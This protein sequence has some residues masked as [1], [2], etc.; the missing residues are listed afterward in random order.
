MSDVKFQQPV[1]TAAT[2]V[3]EYAG[4]KRDFCRAELSDVDL[5]GVDLKGADF[6]YAELSEANL[7]NANLRG[8][9][10]SFANL[11]QANLQ[12]ADLRGA[13]LFSTDLRQ[14]NLQGAKLEKADS[15]R[16]THFPSD[17]D[18]VTAGVNITKV[19]PAVEDIASSYGNPL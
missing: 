10:L 5:S 12:N 9:D 14:A 2:L 11:S 8:C 13:L 1:Y 3:E 6:S 15:D 16:T 17:F 4:G 7:S 18:P 19:D